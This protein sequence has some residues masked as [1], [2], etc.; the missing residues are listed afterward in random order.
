MECPRCNKPLEDA[1]VFCGHCGAL[2]KPRLGAEVATVSD[3]PDTTAPTVMSGSN[4]TL[5]ATAD[6]QSP[7]QNDMPSTIYVDREPLSGRPN[8][9]QE[10]RAWPNSIASQGQQPYTPPIQ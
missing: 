1:A 6:P 10:Q 8:V 7:N 4:S 5:P 9:Q 3:L 2:L